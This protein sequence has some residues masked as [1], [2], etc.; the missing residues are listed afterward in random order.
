MSWMAKKK[1][2]WKLGDPSTE[3]GA[4]LA[5]A[6]YNGQCWFDF[7][8]NAGVLSESAAGTMQM[9]G[10][11][12]TVPTNG[13][14]T[15]DTHG[16]DMLAIAFAAKITA[17][18][19]VTAAT[20][21]ELRAIAW[22]TPFKSSLGMWTSQPSTRAATAVNNTLQ[23]QDRLPVYSGVN[24]QVVAAGGSDDGMA[25]AVAIHALLQADT[26]NPT[27][28]DYLRWHFWIGRRQYQFADGTGLT[29][30]TDQMLSE[31]SIRGYSQV[32]VAM[33]SIAAS[34]LG[35]APALSYAAEMYAV[36]IWDY[37]AAIDINLS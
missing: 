30:A 16:C 11:A 25:E 20:G 24:S 26:T 22:G 31:P 14:V 2:I 28:G 4:A 10:A 27:A 19:D 17:V 32:Q 15:I 23:Q 21:S 13:V 12:G 36:R 3:T 33:L 18:T 34:T 29:A 5:G 7:V 8:T 37:P 6:N 35:G 1:L 9:T